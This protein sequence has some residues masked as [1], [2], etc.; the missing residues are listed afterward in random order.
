[1][2]IFPPLYFFSFLYY[3]DPAAVCLVL[4]MYYLHLHERNNLAAAVGKLHFQW[5]QN[6]NNINIRGISPQAFWLF[7]LGKPTW[8]G[9]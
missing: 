1:M 2:A 9:Q 8:F 3:T 7:L 4:L 6:I 5:N